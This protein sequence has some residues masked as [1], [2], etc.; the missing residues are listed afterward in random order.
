MWNGRPQMKTEV[1]AA[2]DRPLLERWA[3]ICEKRFMYEMTVSFLLLPS[4]PGVGHPIKNLQDQFLPMFPEGAQLGV[5]NGA[6]LAAWSHGRKGPFKERLEP[7]LSDPASGLTPSDPPK[8]KQTAEEWLAEFKA[9]VAECQSRDDIE[10]LEGRCKNALAKLRR[11]RIELGKEA[12][13]A[14]RDRRIDIDADADN[15]GGPADSQRGEGQ[16]LFGE[17]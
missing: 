12:D 8:A 3:P 10:R 7:Q 9:W 1:V 15:Q 5:A 14:V 13:A 16:T 6:A 2:A 17:D 4:A 11:D